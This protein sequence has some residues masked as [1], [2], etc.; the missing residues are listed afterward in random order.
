MLR[1]YCGLGFIASVKTSEA[2]EPG[3]VHGW[4]SI[5]ETER[6]AQR[7]TGY[8]AVGAYGRER[9]RDVCERKGSGGGWSKS[10]WEKKSAAAAAKKQLLHF[11]KK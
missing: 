2:V 1:N 3:Q 9:Q 4:E 8:L 10:S 7:P 6:S 5:T 11:V